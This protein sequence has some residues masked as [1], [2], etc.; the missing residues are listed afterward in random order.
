MSHPWL[1]KSLLVFLSFFFVHFSF[2]QDSTQLAVKKVRILPFGINQHDFDTL[3]AEKLDTAFDAT[4]RFNPLEKNLESVYNLGVA[5][6]PHHEP[7]PAVNFYERPDHGFHQYDRYRLTEQQTLF[8]WVNTPLT[9]VKFLTGGIVE[10]NFEVLHTQN[11]G[12]KFNYSVYYRTISSDGIYS[13]QTAYGKNLGFFVNFAA[14]KNRYH[15]HAGYFQNH[16]YN[17]DNGGLSNTAL[18]ETQSPYLR[19]GESTRLS[20]AES[21]T[22]DKD[23]FLHHELAFAKDSL[24]LGLI[25]FHHLTYK[26]TSFNYSQSNNLLSGFYQSIYYDSLKT[27]D[28]TA[29]ISFSN[30]FGI[31]NL[32]SSKMHFMAEAELWNVQNVGLRFSDPYNGLRFKTELNFKLSNSISWANNAVIIVG[33]IWTGNG[34]LNSSIEYQK[35]NLQIKG[36]VEAFRKQSSLLWNRNDGNLYQWNNN[37]VTTQVIRFKGSIRYKQHILSAEVGRMDKYTYFGLDSLPNVSND[38]ISVATINLFIP[39]TWK[40]LNIHQ[41]ISSYFSSNQTIL[42]TS[43]LSW[44]GSVFLSFGFRKTGLRLQVGSDVFYTAKWQGYGYMP[45]TGQFILQKQMEVGGY[46]RVD[47]FINAYIKRTRLFVKIENAAQGY[48]KDGFFNVAPYPMLDRVWR[49]GFS[50]DFYD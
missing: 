33:N 17:Q 18:F 45:S 32:R 5:G 28:S 12:K 13:K 37:S 31:R 27:Y 42:P 41:R 50:W 16:F 46:P 14:L 44:N 47:L 38:P 15:F 3:L 2:G 30:S 6:S 40:W 8:Y 39:L 29:F 43:P 20:G 1:V 11:L 35:D 36:G 49:L 24:R 4:Q 9:R 19:I 7:I 23:L 26:L 34:S 22:R 48:P 10:Q 21:R 25:L